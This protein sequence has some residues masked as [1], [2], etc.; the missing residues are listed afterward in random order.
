MKSIAAAARVWSCASGQR[1]SKAPSIRLTTDAKAALYKGVNNKG[2]KATLR[3][4][5]NYVR[6]DSGTR[7]CR[8]A[9][10]AVGREKNPIFRGRD[11][12]II[13][14]WLGAIGDKYKLLD[15]LLYP[16]SSR[17]VIKQLINITT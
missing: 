2:S 7:F 3:N 4:K 6:N 5:L 8:T 9:I 16:T 1:P 13:K 11:H 17:L 10:N 15:P 14:S 12:S